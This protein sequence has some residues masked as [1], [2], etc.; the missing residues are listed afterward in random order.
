[1]QVTADDK[2]ARI[3]DMETFSLLTYKNNSAALKEFLS[4][5]ADSMDAKATMYKEI[6]KQGYVYLKDLPDD[7]TKKQSLNTVSTLLYGAGIDNDLRVPDS[8][9]DALEKIKGQL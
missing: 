4:A 5:R 9:L 3:S 1:M 6:S 2:I 7:I 8:A